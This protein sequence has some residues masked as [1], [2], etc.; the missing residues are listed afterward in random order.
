MDQPFDLLVIGGGINGAGIARDAA[1][2][3]LTVALVDAG[4]IGGATSSASTKLIHGGL[5]YLEFYQFGLVRKAL[6]EREVLLDIAPHISWPQSFVLPHSPEQRPE[7]MLRAGTWLYD[8]LARR[9]V[10]PGSAK[11]DLRQDR[12]GRALLPAFRTGFRYWDG[13]VDDARLVIANAQDVRA[14]GGTV[15][16]RTRVAR[17][18]FADGLWTVT[19]GDGRT[20][21]A[22]RIVNAAGPWAEEV[23][24]TVLGRNDAPALRLVQG[25]HL[26]TRR[27]HLGRD[28][29]MLQQPDGRIVFVIPYERDFSLIGT[30]ERSVAAPGAVAMSDDEADYLLAAVNRY[31]ARP[32]SADDVVHRFAG[33]RPLI[34]EAGKGDRETSRDYA[35]VDHAGVPALTVVGGK[36][37]T[38]R[39]LAEA[40]L[41]KIAPRTKAWTAAAPLPGGDVPRLAGENGQAAFKRWLSN[42]TQA[43]ENYDPK[44]VRRLAHTLGTAAEPLLAAGLGDNFGGVFEAELAHFRDAEWARSSDDVLWRRTKLGLHLDPAA[45]ARVAA[46]FG[47]V[48]ASLTQDS[49]TP[50]HRFATP[51]RA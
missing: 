12:A 11:I 10:V 14:R 50:S 3:G 28:A 20:L 44:I 5:R 51:G 41:K 47:E 13:W 37:T 45:K 21:A 39:V 1:G 8:H 18:T 6:A 22:R 40:V 34:V 9:D 48:A 32:L 31:L 43:H 2:R 30:T 15:L 38:Y 17:A 24:R 7:W 36:I 49:R 46:W 25:S 33:V 16:P 42:L 26:V 19:L 27:V 4:D 35:L 29:F 23:A